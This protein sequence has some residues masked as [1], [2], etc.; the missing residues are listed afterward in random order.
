MMRC[1]LAAG[2]LLLC[3]CDAPNRE[4]PA[5]GGGVIVFDTLVTAESGALGEISDM[6]VASD[7][8]VWLTDRINNH[9]AVVDPETQSLIPAGREGE[10]PGE[11]RGPE[12][13]ALS[14]EHLLVFET[15]NRRIQQF[16]PD[17]E[18]VRSAVVE[19]TPFR[20]VALNECGDLALPTLGRDSSL[21]VVI[22]SS[23]AQYNIGTAIAPPPQ[24]QDN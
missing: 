22:R 12:A 8:R 18:F 21:A 9:L 7:G 14:N 10:G 15:R 19:T 23:G 16:T 20:P 13:V 5:A 24:L 1:I 4:E 6:T 11:F 17:A 2:A 3:A